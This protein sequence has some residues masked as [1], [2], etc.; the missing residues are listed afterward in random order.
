MGNALL[1]KRVQVASDGTV[2]L[3]LPIDLRG[4]E[5]EVHIRSLVPETDA[6]LIAEIVRPLPTKTRERYD[7]LMEKRRAETLT[8][9]EY[10]ELQILTDAVESDHLRR[11]ESLGA[12]AKRQGASIGELAVRFGLVVSLA[13]DDL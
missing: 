3:Q 12:L 7:G 10:D 5:V 2:L 8:P 9:E 6:E 4:Q 1:D 11:W 13:N